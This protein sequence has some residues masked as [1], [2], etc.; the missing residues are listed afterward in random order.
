MRD[1][2][3]HA[4]IAQQANIDIADLSFYLQTLA[5]GMMDVVQELNK[6]EGEIDI[7]QVAKTGYYILDRDFL[8]QMALLQNDMRDLLKVETA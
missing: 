5:Q 2:T 6:H 7:T 8:D 4:E 3:T 1:L